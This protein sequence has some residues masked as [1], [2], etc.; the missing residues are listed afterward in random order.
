MILKRFWCILMMFVLAFA[1]GTT[2]VMAAD[3]FDT[4]ELSKG[5]V[6]VSCNAGGKLK[7]MIQKGE[8][9]YTYDLNS[10][11]KKESFPLQLGNGTYKVSVL[12]N[13]SGSS[14]KLLASKSLELKM[15]KP[16]EV[17]L[18]SIQNIDWNEESKA[19]KR[20]VELTQNE[21]D[22]QKK[23]T[24][25]WTYMVNNNTYDYQKMEKL[26]NA[27]GYIPIVDA[28]FVDKTGICYDFASLYAA[29][30]RSQ[31]TPAK[32]IKGYAPKN[33]VGYH[34]WNEVYD[35]SQSKWIVIDTTYDLQI[36]AKNRS[37]TM[38]KN[39]ADFS[40]VYEY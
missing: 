11:G 1:I 17:Y 14:Y 9:K 23:A 28:T 20:A 16:N 2:T 8:E 4:T 6:H 10:S 32:L 38:I 13:T 7:V 33:A 21:P 19:V 29:M 31:G 27:T 35:S 3:Y 25:L 12:K 22:L 37:V 34:A 18:T 40:T 5:L 39:S 30:L 24:I 15:T 36:V 26:A